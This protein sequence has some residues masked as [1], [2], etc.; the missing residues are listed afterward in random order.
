MNL[1]EF[2]IGVFVHVVMYIGNNCHLISLLQL[3]SIRSGLF[4]CMLGDLSMVLDVLM[5]VCL[6]SCHGRCR[7]SEE[8]RVGW[9]GGKSGG[10]E[11]AAGI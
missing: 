9:H 2:E 3:S 1:E 4:S 11:G 10:K 8:R 7:V 5:S 6:R